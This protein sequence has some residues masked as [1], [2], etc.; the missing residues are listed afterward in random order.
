MT[1]PTPPL[2]TQRFW[3]TLG[4]LLTGIFLIDLLTPLGVADGVLYIAAVLFSLGQRNSRLVLRV[5]SGCSVLTVV[6]YGISPD[7]GE[8]WIAIWNR[9]FALFA[10]WTTAT[11][12]NIHVQQAKTIGQRETTFHDFVNAMPSG[13]FTFDR[14]GTILSWNPAA[15]RIYGFSRQEAI[16]TYR[17][18]LIVT[19]E[20]RQATQQAIEA[21]FKGQTLHNRL[22]HDRK[23]NVEQGSR[24]GNFFPIFDGQGQVLYGVHMNVDMSAPEARLA[25]PR[26]VPQGLIEAMADSMVSKDAQGHTVGLVGISRD[27]TDVTN[28]QRELILSELVF[29]ASPDHIAVVGKDY[30][31]RRVNPTYERVHGKTKQEL[32]GL[33]ITDL[34]GETVFA[35]QVQPFIDRCFRGEEVHYESWFTFQD[36]ESRYMAVSYIPLPV[37]DKDSEEIVVISRDWTERKTAEEAVKTNERRLRTILDAMTNFIGIGTVDGIILECNQAPLALAGLQREDVIGKPF[38]DTYWLNY[39][40]T[41]QEQIRKIL[42]RVA[43]GEI[44]REDVQAR[45]GENRYITVDACYVPVKD[46]SGQVVQIVHSGIDVTARRNAEKA[47]QESKQKLQAILDHS[48]NLIFMKDLAGRYLH[49]NKQFEEVFRLAQASVLG[50]DDYHL[51]S[52]AQAGQFHTHDRMVLQ[53]GKTLQFEEEALHNDGVLHTSLV[54]KFPLQDD[55]GSTY[56]IGGIA[57][58]ITDRKRAEESLRNSE[59]RFRKYFE[60][61]LVGMAITAVNKTFLEVN[62]RICTILG[63][64][65]EELLGKDWSHLTHPDDLAENLTF[66]NQLLEGDLDAFVMEKRYLHKNGSTIHANLYMTAIKNHTGRVDY[67]TTMVQD[68]TLQKEAQQA[69]RAAEQLSLATMNALSAYICVLNDHGTIIMVNDGWKLFVKDNAC[70]PDGVG[71]GDNYFSFFSHI[72]KESTTDTAQT[73]HHILE[74]LE[75]KKKEFSFEFPSCHSPITQRWFACRV[76][77]FPGPGSLRVVVA[78]QDITER[79][80]V[81]N[82]LRSSES[83]LKTFFDSAPMMMGV[84][85]ISSQD[86]RHLSDNKATAR[87]YGQVEGGV[88]GKWCSELDIPR[89]IMRIWMD[90]YLQSLSSQQPVSFEYAHPSSHGTRWVSAVVTPVAFGTLPTSQCAYIAQDIT[91]RKVMEEQIRQHTIELEAEV[92]RRATR[93]QELEQRRMQVEKLAALSQVA[94]GVAHEINNPLA[95]IAQSLTLLKRAIPSDHPRYKYTQKMQECIDRMTHITRQLYSLY[96]PTPS[97][98]DSVEVEQ[99]IQSALEIMHP[100]AHKKGIRLR[101]SVSGN[102]TSTQVGIAPADLIQI[103]CNLIQNAVDASSPPSD[104]HVSITQDHETVTIAI[105]DQGMGIAPD[106]LPRMFDPFYTT[107][108]GD[109]GIGLGLGLAISKNIIESASGHLR[110]STIQGTGT[111]FSIIL[112]TSIVKQ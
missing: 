28:T 50:F 101:S 83:T 66:F 62:D 32:V 87:F 21:V 81:E 103:L 52:P 88:T 5:A 53:A 49:V 99:V 84:V 10:I 112:P 6:G 25:T 61:G 39:S 41:V 16:G 90:H 14:Q 94:A 100:T 60:S 96:R 34:L 9:V 47:L 71:V 15:E 78:H 68:L 109:Q 64:S 108:Y 46:A 57:T 77:R 92:E 20:T 104:I 1:G 67:I 37:P 65:R 13:C 31:Y 44:V 89:D 40:P 30:R 7:G 98:T 19:P 55:T 43:Q 105:A 69:T 42:H 29:N 35:H 17:W 11:M 45:M 63:Y 91:E 36:G 58:D 85:E 93:I 106:V 95:S 48:P 3:F 107:K 4:M 102:L 110:C 75:G 12:G 111:T 56:A 23:K 2:S 76:T 79:K 26:H 82:A 51:F 70:N 80:H 8:W 73:V 72:T 97:P 59:E 38:I 18:D 22:W 24:L 86:V 33:S 54:Q 27:N 74:V